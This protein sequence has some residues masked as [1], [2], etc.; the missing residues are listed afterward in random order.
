LENKRRCAGLSTEI[1]NAVKAA[2]DKAQYDERAKRLLSQK[3]ILAHILVKT[4]DEFKGMNPKDVVSYIEGEPKVGIVPLEPGMTNKDETPTDGERVVGLNIENFDINEG[5]VRFDI[6]FYVRMKDGLSQI[7]VNVEAQQKNPTEYDILNR[8]IFYVCRMVSSQKERDFVKS[9]YNDIKRVTSI[10]ICLNMKENSMNHYHLTN[11]VLLGN[12]KWKGKEDM[13]NIVLLGLSKEIPEHDKDY[14]LHRLLGVL[15]SQSL[16]QDEKLNIIGNEYD[17]PLEDE[18][19]R[20]LGSMCNLSQ[21]IVEE[22]EE[23]I[24]MS[25]YDNDIAVEKIAVIVNKTIEEVK[26]IIESNQAVLV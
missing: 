14:E 20:E 8:A 25:M 11:D 23:K 12:Q 13:I 2:D 3:H 6:I 17:I 15:L 26:K 18:F 4:V 7:I 19:R 1:T 10:W 24:I 9:N 21:G 16:T 5:L 22:T